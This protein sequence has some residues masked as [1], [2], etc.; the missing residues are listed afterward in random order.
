MNTANDLKDRLLMPASTPIA[1]SVPPYAVAMLLVTILLEVCG[2]I[3][4]KGAL[5]DTRV[6]FPAYALYFAGLSMFSFSLRYIP[7]SVAYTTW[8]ALGTIGVAIASRVVYSE[9]L[10]WRQWACIVMTIPPV[11]GLY[12]F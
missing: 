6:F 8:C 5:Y 10:S 3:L 7:L 12:V 1:A 4:L 9:T 2:T 11:V